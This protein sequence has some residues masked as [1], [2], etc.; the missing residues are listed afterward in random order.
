MVTDRE[1]EGG[2]LY[3][4][5]HAAWIA[6]C[7]ANSPD[8]DGDEEPDEGNDDK[9]FDERAAFSHLL[10][11]VAG[12]SDAILGG[13]TDG[14]PETSTEYW[15]YFCRSAARLMKAGADFDPGV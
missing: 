12:L 9:G 15:H 3:A 6:I 2:P 4:K 13:V 5:F 10:D 11:S 14:G 7:N 8:Q 1:A